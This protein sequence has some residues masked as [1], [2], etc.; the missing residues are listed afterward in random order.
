M[1]G[2]SEALQSARQNPA[3]AGA[4]FKVMKTS[5]DD[6]AKEELDGL[7]SRLDALETAWSEVFARSPLVG[8]TAPA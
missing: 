7:D 8:C 2:R 1:L 3:T 6:L 4:A 5:I